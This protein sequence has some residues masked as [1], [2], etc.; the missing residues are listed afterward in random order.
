MAHYSD[1]PGSRCA[2]T[3]PSEPTLPRLST[4]ADRSTCFYASR[5]D[6]AGSASM[7]F[8]FA[9]SRGTRDST[10][11]GRYRPHR[12]PATAVWRLQ[13]RQGRPDAEIPVDKAWQAGGAMK[14]SQA[15]S[16]HPLLVALAGSVVTVVLAKVLEETDLPLASLLIASFAGLT[17]GAIL[18]IAT[19]WANQWQE[20]RDYQERQRRHDSKELESLQKDIYISPD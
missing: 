2:T 12:Q 19:V 8:C 15:T 9:T 14:H 4:T 16:P 18:W 11:T 13:Q 7:T 5:K 6:A 20:G 3:P 10:V 17:V 1:A